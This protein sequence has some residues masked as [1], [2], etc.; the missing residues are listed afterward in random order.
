MDNKELRT[1]T[2]DTFRMIGKII[3]VIALSLFFISNASAT[4]TTDIDTTEIC[5]VSSLNPDAYLNN[6]FQVYN[7]WDTP[8]HFKYTFLEFDDMTSIPS[9]STIISATL[10][11]Y[12]ESGQ[13]HDLNFRKINESWNNATVT[14]NTKP[15][16][17]TD[18]ET[19]QYISSIGWKEFIITDIFKEWYTGQTLNYGLSGEPGPTDMNMNFDTESYI[20][21]SYIANPQMVY[22]QVLQSTDTGDKSVSNAVVTIWNS[23]NTN[24]VVSGTDGSYSFPDISDGSY[25]LRVSKS[26]YTDSE[27]QYLNMS[28]A[29]I[30]KNVY[31]NPIGGFGQYYDDHHVTF[32]VMNALFT[33]YSGVN[34]TVYKV[35]DGSYIDADTTDELGQVT[36]T[37]VKDTKYEISF[38]DDSIGIN[39][40][41]YIYP[42]KTSYWIFVSLTTNE[43]NEYDTSPAES[44]TASV[45]RNDYSALIG[46][47]N[48]TY[49]TSVA[50]TTALTF[51]LNQTDA[52]DPMNQTVIDSWNGGAADNAFH[53]FQIGTHSGESYLVHVYADHSTYG[54][55]H[56]NFGVIFPMTGTFDGIPEW[57]WLYLGVFL[58]FITGALAL[59]TM[60][61]EG[62]IVVCAEGWLFFMMG[63][64]EYMASSNIEAG[65]TVGTILA[66]LSYLAKKNK[67]V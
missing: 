43:W 28:V 3:L 37:L 14:W 23:T 61:E 10:Y 6:T 27:I 67:E 53:S 1:N 51:Y 35:S 16:I 48:V 49:N 18:N 5:M 12:V 63:W 21:V 54:D 42:S 7:E 62:F 47:V 45:V 40:T 30:E 24:S 64:F 8:S 26:G 29:G 9:G 38:I 33:K 60:P 4:T 55:V 32:T 50:G 52:S 36:I 34:V 59:S 22:G 25:N 58:M 11:V 19:T 65:L 41:K 17:T 57:A 13:N 15:G 20:R 39:T 56:R 46:Y 31:V 2:G 44:V 66:I